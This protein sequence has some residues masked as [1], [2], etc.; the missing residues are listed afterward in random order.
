[1]SSSL[2]KELGNLSSSSASSEVHT[3]YYFDPFVCII[4]GRNSFKI[5]VGLSSWEKFI[6]GLLVGYVASSAAAAGIE[7]TIDTHDL[8]F[9]YSVI[10]SWLV[11]LKS[12]NS[13]HNPW[14]NLAPSHHVLLRLW[15][16]HF[17]LYHLNESKGMKRNTQWAH[18]AAS[19]NFLTLWNSSHTCSWCT[20]ST[21]L[22]V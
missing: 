11:P 4:S 20:G 12:N 10:H 17:F 1:M 19:L 15:L 22:V 5:L 13:D 8:L 21:V 7:T 6:R 2:L 3:M 14:E 9:I 18:L 16:L